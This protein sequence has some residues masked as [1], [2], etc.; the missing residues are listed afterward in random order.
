MSWNQKGAA[1]PQGD[2]GASGPQGATGATGAT[3][4]QGVPGPEGALTI[5]TVTAGTPIFNGSNQ[6][7]ATATCPAGTV[8]TGGGLSLPVYGQIF[9]DSNP[10]A[11]GTGWYGSFTAGPYGYAGTVYAQCASI[12]K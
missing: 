1:G 9:L 4:P 6:P 10:T 5:T 3:G 11:D 2:T 12:A 8:V 7:S